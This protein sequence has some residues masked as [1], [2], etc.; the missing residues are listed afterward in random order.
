MAYTRPRSRRE[1]ALSRHRRSDK[2]SLNRRSALRVHDDSVR[3]GTTLP[4]GVDTIDAVEGACM[5]FDERDR[6]GDRS[7]GYREVLRAGPSRRR[8]S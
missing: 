8:A 7:G 3:I 5:I 2:T 6:P 4:V 1:A